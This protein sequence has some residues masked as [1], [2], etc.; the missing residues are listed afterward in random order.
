MTAAPAR[1]RAIRGQAVSLTGNPFLSEGCLQHVADAL[2]LIEDGRITDF[3]DFSDLSDRIPAGVEVVAY[4][5]ALILPGLIDTHVHYPQLQMIASYGE[6]LL[7]WLEKYTFPAELQFADQAHAER[8]A[9]LFFR[10]ILGA[11]TTTAVVYCTVHPGSVE[12]FFAESARFNTRMIAGKVLMD[13]NAPAGLLDTAQR[14]YDESRAL[15]ERWHGRGR[16][17]Y[18]VTPRF[19]PSC[20]QA[21]LDAAGTLMREHDALF[22]Q[23]HLCENTDEIAWVRELFPDRASYL[24]VYVQ[25]GLV[26]PRTVLGHAVHMSE[27][28]FCTCHA[29]G[30]AIAH[31]PTSNGFLGSGL[32]RL[33]DA[34]DPRR[35]VRVGLGTDVGAG[36]TLSLLKTLGESYK[37][38]ALRG[39]K[40][41]AVRAFWLATL[42]GAEA[43]RLDDR[44][45][46]IAPG[47]DADLCVLDLAATPLLGFRTGTCAS[48]EELLFV[49]MTLG[50]HRTVR[51]TWVAGEAVY[52]NRRAGDPL[53]YPGT[54]G[55]V[56]AGA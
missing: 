15:I 33:F 19:A 30:A 25:S 7:A 26:G 3:G 2:I 4:E 17:H 55:A 6:Q 13:R 50:D 44:I 36:T 31:C 16:Q 38:A 9:R 49:L 28:D 56:G 18:C 10:E 1:I 11:G 53:V 39:T 34:L 45:G 21:Q 37:V 29:R 22:L 20:T 35:P 8:V 23:T 43:L 32:F 5:N 51:A 42:G 46:R 24:D 12:A 27:E 48:I 54:D 47:H 41:D 52:D 14:G 40:L